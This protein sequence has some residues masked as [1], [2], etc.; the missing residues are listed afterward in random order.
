MG[1]LG[2]GCV[3]SQISKMTT[4]G[5]LQMKFYPKI[6]RKRGCKYLVCKFYT[7]ENKWCQKDVETKK[8]INC[9]IKRF[10]K[11]YSVRNAFNF[12]SVL[13]IKQHF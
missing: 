11:H 6:F 3:N 10:L 5:E 13:F 8:C 4:F 12:F 9:D 1:L 7:E 2:I